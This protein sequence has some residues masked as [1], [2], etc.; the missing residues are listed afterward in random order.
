MRE[1]EK[2]RVGLKRRGSQGG[3]KGGSALEDMDVET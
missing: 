3:L 2:K 1:E